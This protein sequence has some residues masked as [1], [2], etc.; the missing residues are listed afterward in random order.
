M[1]DDKIKVG[2][3]A[4]PI[5]RV[6]RIIKADID[7]RLCSKESIFLIG[8][9]TASL[10]LPLPLRDLQLSLTVDSQEYMIGKLTAQAHEKAMI[11]KRPK[12]IKYSDLGTLSPPATLTLSY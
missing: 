6:H 10:P 4:L 5:S 8:K 12:M 2:T 1:S 11:N 7:V 3:S 9:A